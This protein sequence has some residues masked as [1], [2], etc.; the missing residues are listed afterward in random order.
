MSYPPLRRPLALAL[1]LAA[2]LAGGARQAEGVWIW[3]PKTGKWINPKYAVKDTPEEQYHFA[4]SFFERKDYAR[5][6]IEFKNLLRSFPQSAWAPDAQIGLARAYEA[7][8]D[9][10]QAFLEYRKALQTYPSVTRVDEIVERE[11][12]IGELFLK[13]QKR[14]LLGSAEI[15]PAQEKA[16]EVFQAILDDAPYAKLGDQAQFKLGESYRVIGQFDEAKAAFEALAERYPDSPLAQQAR[17]E[18][19]MSARRAALP[20][21]YDATPADQALQEFAKFKEEFPDS[22]LQSDVDQEMTKLLEQ[23]AQHAFEVAQFYEKTK[24]PESA[25]IYYRDL[26]TNYQDSPWAAQAQT[27]L[28]AL[29]GGAP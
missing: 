8:T 19:A 13:G 1:L 11:F 9:Y 17:F 5:A 27:R 26:V 7:E 3:T 15:I 21:A 18:I 4:Q 2:C 10:Y 24:H 28:Q 20:P 29:G 12:H 14:R 22:P 25:K 16:V 6:R 23:R